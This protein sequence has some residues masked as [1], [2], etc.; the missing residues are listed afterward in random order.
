MRFLLRAAVLLAA[1][2]PFSCSEFD[3]SDILDR[4]DK[5]E[6]RVTALERQVAAAN[7]EIASLKT[8]L[9]AMAAQDVVTSIRAIEEDGKAGWEITYS[10]SGTS[11]IFINK[12]YVTPKIGVKDVGGV[13]YW[14]I[15]GEL[16]L[17][18]S[19]KWIPA[20]AKNGTDGTNGTNGTNG[21]TP[22]LKIEGGYWY[23]SYDNEETWVKLGAATAGSSNSGVV[24]R[25][26]EV[27]EGNVVFTLN[28][29]TVYTIPLISVTQVKAFDENAIVASFGVMSDTHIG[30]GY[31]SEAKFTAALSQLKGRAAEKDADG[32]DA[33]LIAGDLVNTV[34]QSQISTL[35]S[36]YEAQFDPKK[37]P[38]IYAVG[39]HDM[40]PGCKWSVNTVTQN[41]VFRDILGDDYFLTDQDQAMRINFECRHCIV[42]NYHIIAITPNNDDPVLYD[43]DATTWLDGV[44]KSV[45]EAD[46]GRYVL[47]ITHPMIYNTVYGSTLGTY[48]YTSSLTDI[49]NKYPQVVTFGGHLHFPLNDPRSIW[50]GGFTAMGCASV[51]YMA[52]EGGNYENKSSSTVLND[53]GE[54]SEGLLVQFDANGFMRATRMDFYRS[55]VIGKA[56]ET[57]PPASDKS[58]LEKY[59]HIGLAAANTAPSLSTLSFEV[60]ALNDGS[61]PVSAKWAAGTDDEFVHHYGYTL[62]KDGSTLASKFIMSD[63]YRSP[64]TSMM[65]TEYNFSLGNLAEGTYKFQIIAYDSWGAES[66]PLEKEFSVG[67]YSKS[68]WTGDAA[69]SADYD[70]GTGSVSGTWLSY[71]TGHVSWTANTSGKPR[72]EQIALPNGELY[73]VT[74]VSAADLKGTWAFRTQ[75]FSNNT[76][77]TTAAPDITM[78]I[79]IGDALYGET[80]TD[81]DGKTYTNNLGVRG[82]YLDAVADA[83]FVI[84]YDNRTARFGLFL[85]ERKAQ[86]VSN[87]NATY[88]YV[89][90]IPE[91][92]ASANAVES[93]WNFVPVPVGTNNNYTWLWFN[94][95]NDFSKLNYD[96][97]FQKLNT[98]NPHTSSPYIIGIT[99]A[100]C[101]NASPAAA[102]IYDTYNVI[103]QANPNKA[104]TNGGFTLTRK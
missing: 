82:L 64:Q 48:W 30:N 13:L 60:G 67:A 73:K 3:D 91:L 25:S 94:F 104:M 29:G 5:L 70:G 85:D 31:G 17:D 61:A 43:A 102:D 86:S 26:V 88:P 10:K 50:Q 54:Y 22:K 69:G 53:A 92:G 100:V 12:D 58:H 15:D 23:V 84:D 8:L 81:I 103:Y 42:G 74:Q 90:F 97:P 71:T 80:L 98:A 89:C 32:L 87:G 45:T 33:V 66:A 83:A 95:L 76:N 9:D 65:K 47:L 96:F 16:L 36:L 27:V 18:A 57:A 21:I 20:S 55:A 39:N 68:K 77:V 19:G 93:P 37:V 56:W 28:D 1:L 79:T 34:N 24:F 75:R 38:M 52:F 101:K 46:P 78:D 41:A 62:T 49:L 44:L 6:E 40:N 2:L 35:K 72:S 7:T 51:S 63:F 99:C 11:K 4:L 14:T 59:N